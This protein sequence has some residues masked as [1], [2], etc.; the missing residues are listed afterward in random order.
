MLI[1]HK[2]DDFFYNLFPNLKDSS[3]E[4]ILL[5]IDDYYSF[6]PYKPKISLQEKLLKIE[7]DIP[8]IFSQKADF[9]KVVNLCEQRK[10][11]V[12]KPILQNLLLKNP[13]NAEY[14]RVMGQL[15]SDSGDN[16]S[17]MDSMI[18]ALRWDSRNSSALLMMGNLLFKHMRDTEAAMKYYNQALKLNPNDYVAINNIAANFMQQGDFDRARYYFGEV[19]KINP[20]YPN[21]YL[22]LSIMAFSE[23]DLH[24]AFKLSLQSIKYTKS[25]DPLHKHI[26]KQLFESADRIVKDGDSEKISK[27]YFEKLEYEG[28]LSIKTI[29]D[30]TIGTAAKIEFAENYSR[31]FH[32]I[33][34]KESEPAVLHL[35]MHELVHLDF[36][37]Q[38]KK[39][40]HNKLFISTQ[41]NEQLFRNNIE[42]TLKKL[43]S[44]GVPAQNIEGYTKALFNGL[45]SQI[46]NAP[47]DLF[48]ENYL[49]ITYPELRPYQLISLNN[50]IQFGKQ[51]VT[52]K[53]I[54]DIS[55]R[56]IVACSRIYN[57]VAAI[58]FKE[59][60]GIDYTS[61]FNASKSELKT[62]QDFYDEFVEYKDDRAPAEEYELLMHW[63]EDLKLTNYFELRDE[64]EF[65]KPK[66]D[67]EELLDSIE[68]DPFGLEKVDPEMEK[69]MADF[70]EK[71]RTEKI[72]MA[73]VMHMA[74]AL[75][76]FRD[77]PLDK[78]KEIAFEIAMQG[79]MGYNTD[80]GEYYLHKI[81]GKKFSGYQILSYYYV[82]WALA[83]PEMLKE[84]QLPFD[85]EYELV[86]SF[87]K[88][89]K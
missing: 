44:M 86:L 47:I 52:D 30:A 10:Y 75:N 70:L 82:S 74:D 5:Y 59:L 88:N 58:Q 56:E 37:I 26:V 43:K 65:R 50:V 45:N 38:A 48:I 46:F 6:G 84:L 24:D 36:V 29:I 54:L 68:K 13:S 34:Y 67:I 71:H 39:N 22:A 69:E 3:E 28:G 85:K 41:K 25:N 17:A 73:V 81:P 18:T 49:F 20:E 12:A 87:F 63:A 66:D 89:K 35:I 77:M 78:V 15:L 23:N 32:L 21:T 1:I 7:I 62:A 8:A 57:L 14:H 42:P 33:R 31:D 55:P 9:E 4:Q 27:K 83:I 19:L 60:Y 76:Y 11:D 72:N 61:E 16:E 2:I 79:R 80:N 64:N 53:K 40:A 51:A